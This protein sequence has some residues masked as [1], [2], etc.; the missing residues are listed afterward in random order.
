[1]MI[2][3]QYNKVTLH[4]IDELQILQCLKRGEFFK[5]SKKNLTRQLFVNFLKVAACRLQHRR[6]YTKKFL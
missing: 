3:F 5:I 2:T 4:P 6:D 1:M